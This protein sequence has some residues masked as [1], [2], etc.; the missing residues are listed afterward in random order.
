MATG[1]FFEFT[2]LSS[3]RDGQLREAATKY[4]NR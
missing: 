1:F 2:T 3:I 4:G